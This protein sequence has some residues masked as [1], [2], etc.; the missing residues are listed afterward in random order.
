[1]GKGHP[2]QGCEMSR[3]PAKSGWKDGRIQGYKRSNGAWSLGQGQESNHRKT[4]A[5]RP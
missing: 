3:E 1:M 5:W 2:S 4:T